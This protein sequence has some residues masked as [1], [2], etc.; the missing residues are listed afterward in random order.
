[1]RE[2]RFDAKFS[3]SIVFILTVIMGVSLVRAALI[4]VPDD[5]GSPRGAF[6]IASPGDEIFIRAGIY[7][8]DYIVNKCLTIYG[9]VSPSGELLTIFDGAFK[10]TPLKVTSN[11]SSIRDLVVQNSPLERGF[12]GIMVYGNGNTFESSVIR[13]CYHGIWIRGK[14]Q[15][16]ISTSALYDHVQAGI[17]MDKF[18]DRNEIFNCQFH[19]SAIGIHLEE[20][21]K[22]RITGNVLSVQTGIKLERSK[23]NRINQNEC[24]CDIGNAEDDSNLNIWSGNGWSDYAALSGSYPLPGGGGADDGEPHIAFVYGHAAWSE[25][26]DMVVP[27]DYPTITAAVAAAGDGDRIY[28]K[29]GVYHEHNIDI[30]AND[31]TIFGE[32]D[33]K[34]KLITI[35][36]ADMTGCGFHMIKS[37]IRVV[38][39]IIQ[40]T[41]IHG[42]HNSGV[43]IYPD[44]EQD[45]VMNCVI[46]NCPC[47]VQSDEYLAG[48]CS[49]IMNNVF[50]N[51]SIAGVLTVGTRKFS[52]KGNQFHIDTKTDAAIILDDDVEETEV[53]DNIVSTGDGIYLADSNDNYIAGNEITCDSSHSH[54]NT[55]ANTW[56][57][58]G[59]SDYDSRLG[60]YDIPGG[61][62]RDWLPHIAYAFMY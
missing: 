25:T 9:E 59:F 57:G 49:S 47:G 40:N 22:N 44:S 1:M 20:G 60:R 8:G 53:V 35:V 33:D 32:V 21:E 7:Y 31:I 61:P 48:C 34:G 56:R 19:S 24:V 54:D 37:G 13:N 5:I 51:N 23:D 39:I 29:G 52:I 50:Y 18:S 16:K 46:R 17:R 43:F 45:A 58:N 26:P 30:I 10:Y 28:V 12:A 38:N 62:G 36:D 15:N 41:D 27:D 6:A 2:L 14:D 11:G 3:I 55:G 42:I 4:V